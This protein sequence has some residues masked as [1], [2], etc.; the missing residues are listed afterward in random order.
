VAECIRGD[1]IDLLIDTT[2]HTAKNRML[3]FARKPAPVQITSLFTTGLRTMDYRLTDA[4]L[5][6][7]GHEDELYCEQPLRLPNCFWCF[8]PPGNVPAVNVLPG[9][10][11]GY[12][13]FGSLNNFVKI[14]PTVLRLWA[15]V[16]SAIPGSRMILQCSA[17]DHQNQV[18]EIFQSAGIVPERVELV[19]RGGSIQKYFEQYHRIDICLDPTPFS[20]H[21]TSFD[22]LWMGVPL[23]TLAGHTVVG[24]SGVSILSNLGL[25]E[26]I[27]RTPAE[28]VSIA[29]KLA[30]NLPKLAEMRAGM[31]QK[32]LASSLMDAARYARDTE[33]AYRSV[34]R[35]WCQSALTKT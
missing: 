27:A 26:L 5:D 29:V 15:E 22:T 31:R 16:L 6:P 10:S 35:A 34:W 12:I 19:P 4:Y 30:G 9:L 11:K 18:R 17:G 32:M 3:L 13:T 24:R 23:V 20:G 1:R 21:T 2:A 28:Y 7:P 25:T 14:N 8:E 33:A